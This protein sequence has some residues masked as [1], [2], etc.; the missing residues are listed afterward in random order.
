MIYKEEVEIEDN[1]QET[2]EEQPIQYETIDS[3][4]D[5]PREQTV[6]SLQPP[7]IYVEQSG[8]RETEVP[9]RSTRTRQPV[10]KLEYERLGGNTV[11]ANYS[12]RKKIKA[13]FLKFK[14]R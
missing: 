5:T 6:S 8:S 9:R 1:E 14:K 4:E 11:E 12:G 10:E 3:D 2:Q 7:N 13:W